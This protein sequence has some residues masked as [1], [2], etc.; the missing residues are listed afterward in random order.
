MNFN[1]FFFFMVFGA[2]AKLV[3]EL[4]VLSFQLL[5]MIIEA[6]INF[7]QAIKSKRN[8]NI[9]EGKENENR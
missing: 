3:W 9:N 7:S 1:P 2:F 4:C 8:K 6:I 5:S